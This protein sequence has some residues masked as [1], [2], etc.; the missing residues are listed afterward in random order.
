MAFDVVRLLHP[1]DPEAFK[2]A[3]WEKQPLR[4]ARECP[5][6]YAELFSLRQFDDLLSHSRI[7]AGDVR[8]A[9]RGKE[10]PIRTLSASGHNGSVGALEHLYAQYREGCS[11]ALNAFDQS[12]G[13]LR[14]FCRTIAPE[15]SARVQVNA[16]L[17]PPHQQGLS[18]H[19]DTHDVFVLQIWGAKHWCLHEGGFG[20]PL[21]QHPYQRSDKPGAVVDEFDLRQGDL[22]YIPRGCVHTASSSTTASLHLT[23]GIHPIVWATVLAGVLQAAVKSDQSFRESLPLGFQREEKAR[24]A[25]IA[26]L[27]ELLERLPSRVDPPAVID[28]AAEAA[29][30]GVPPSLEGHL[31]DLV[32]VD[33]IDEHTRLCRRPGLTWKLIEDDDSV[34]LRF[35]G[36]E[37]RLPAHVAPTLRDL[38]TGSSFSLASLR[39]G[40]DDA[41][42]MVLARCL[43]TEGFLTLA[44]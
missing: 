23:I 15:F 34:R 6:Y 1:M 26:K 13:P 32:A 14:E 16:Y 20:L 27:K 2:E 40:L 29:R 25:A 12:T 22:L 3:Y 42:R 11:I 33:D 5:D 24:R 30:R 36:K 37:V 38:A 44:S 28:D 8:I 43:V 41:E 17:S 19:Y 10:T 4:L 7:R 18:T 31:A 39:S 9:S 21:S 35:H